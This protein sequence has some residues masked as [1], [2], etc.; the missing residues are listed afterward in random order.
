MTNSV[1]SRVKAVRESLKID[2]KKM[3][4]QVFAEKLGTTRSVIANIEYGRVEPTGI[5]IKLIC[6]TFDVD[7]L[8]LTT[9][10][11]EMFHQSLDTLQDKVNDL[12]EGENET[13]RAVFA[14]F[15][16]F[17]EQDWQTVQK[18]MDAY[19]AHK[20]NGAG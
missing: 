13:A 5:I 11:G 3:T 7:Y 14:A 19:N 17:S 20:K 6:S 4:Q 16:E 1:S 12:L 10:Q 15:T 2:G 18:F 8:W 9:G